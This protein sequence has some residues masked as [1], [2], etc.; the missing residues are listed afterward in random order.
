MI[1]IKRD[2]N[3][4]YYEEIWNKYRPLKEVLINLSKKFTKQLYPNEIDYIKYKPYFEENYTKTIEEELEIVKGIDKYNPYLDLSGF[5][6]YAVQHKFLHLVENGN[7]RVCV[8]NPRYGSSDII[9]AHKRKWNTVLEMIHEIA[10]GYYFSQMGGHIS[11]IAPLTSETL[12]ILT[13]IQLMEVLQKD[14]PCKE[15]FL[16]ILYK[17]HGR[18]VGMFTLDVY[19]EEVLKL[20]E[21][22]LEKIEEIRHNLILSF[23]KDIS[24][25][26]ESYSK[27]NI[28]L[29]FELL[30]TVREPYLYSHAML[31]AFDLYQR[32]HDTPS[33]QIYINNSNF[34]H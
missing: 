28:L 26:N 18:F 13:E 19:E 22:S 10:H 25:V 15:Y 21:Y 12:S 20:P 33:L 34:P 3:F 27:H 14:Y 1:D 16:T 31:L 32:I 24:V 4:A 17:F 2:S 8:Y 6:D 5:I 11:E 30:F 7:N 9:I 23:T 29:S